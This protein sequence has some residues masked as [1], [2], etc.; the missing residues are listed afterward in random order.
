MTIMSI[1]QTII[2]EMT[3][4]KGQYDAMVDYIIA[5][6]NEI[7]PLDPQEKKEENLV[8]DCLSHVWIVP[9]YH[10]D[11]LSLQGDSDSMVTKGLL[12]LL[13]RVFSEQTINDILHSNLFFIE[14]LGLH[15]ILSMRRKGGMQAIIQHIYNLAKTYKKIKINKN[16]QIC[17]L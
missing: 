13:L 7:P 14:Q 11:S 17:G 10:N 15:K 1:Q 2:E 6:G 16:E 4:L 12:A 5:I 9:T 8:A 3:M